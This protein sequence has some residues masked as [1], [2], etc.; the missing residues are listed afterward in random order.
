MSDDLLK[1]YGD[2]VREGKTP[3]VVLKLIEAELARRMQPPAASRSTA[4]GPTPVGT[5]WCPHCEK[6]KP[7]S[8]FG[9]RRDRGEIKRQS[10][11]KTCRATTNYHALPRKY[12]K[13][14]GSVH[15]NE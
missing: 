13:R 5:K 1:I 7:L 11:C 4:P 8:E 12:R 2:L 10:W 3:D 6:Y 14:K 15:R 9:P